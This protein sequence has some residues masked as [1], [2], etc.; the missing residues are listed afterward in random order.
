MVQTLKNNRL[1]LKTARTALLT[2]LI[3][4]QS[5][6]LFGCGGTS[7]S[8]QSF[9]F[10]VTENGLPK[11]WEINSYEN[12]YECSTA[13]GVI[14]LSS[15]IADDLRATIEV[16]V[17]PNTKY[18]L[19]GYIKTDNVQDGRGA[20]LSIDNYSVDKSCVYSTGMLG[21]NDWQEVELT[22][23]TIKK[24]DTIV[25]ALR[26]GGYSEAS[27]GSVS[28]RDVSLVQDDSSDQYYQPLNPWSSSTNDSDSD[29]VDAE[30]LKAFF[31]VINWAAVIAAVV[32]I[33]GVLANRRRI[34]KLNLSDS[35]YKLGIAIVIVAGLIIR[36]LLV[37]KYKGHDTDMN[38]WIAWGNMIASGNIST[39]YV[40]TWY[41]YPPAYM[42][43]LG[44]L[45]AIVNFFGINTS[46]AFGL[47]CYNIPPILGDI[48]CMVLLM[49][50]AQKRGLPKSY[51]LT[52][53][54]LVFLN[55]AAMFLSGAWCQI[56]CILTF[57]L[58]LSFILINQN[59]RIPAALV[60]A[61]AVLFKWQALMFGPILAVY[62][63]VTIYKSRN[64]MRDIWLTVAGVASALAL[65][66]VVSL[67]FKGTQSLFWIVEKF[68]AAQGSYDYASVE[69]YNF[70][71]LCGGNWPTASADEFIL[72]ISYKAFGVFSIAIAIIA[73]SVAMISTRRNQVLSIKTPISREGLLFL[74]SAFVMSWIFTFGHYMHERYIFPV[75]FMLL[76]AYVY[77]KDWR[78]LLLSM[79]F[80]I[81][82]FANEMTAMYVVSDAAADVV[83]GGREH[84]DMI[85]FWSAVET[86]VEIYFA[87]VMIKL[88]AK[89]AE[90]IQGG[91]TNG[92]SMA[93]GR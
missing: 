83:R 24:Q 25:V 45:S 63:I 3:L 72:G 76:F 12:E 40:G 1:I 71:A 32:L 46:S 84:S 53:G 86:A 2:A 5:L 42:L 73:G 88:V 85:R 44:L 28:F 54:A 43:V 62:Y 14:T 52:L 87:Y 37:A 79:L 66:F 39:F 90:M 22:F 8:E 92:K 68:I 29:T 19:R 48:G 27:S 74:T 70:I 16:S 10:T 17:S 93:K 78:L 56:D 35:R 60:Y 41:D 51:V 69:A 6:Q 30:T 31:A 15:E 26:L 65:I 47:F 20:S 21:S 4:V 7:V 11:G 9:D 91:E 50:A 59:R 13:N 18:I 55:P 34:M 75:L 64:V 58:V 38:C 67:P 89:P 81:T 57:F 23:E 49:K 77:C 80:T 36:F 61:T 82:C 33:A